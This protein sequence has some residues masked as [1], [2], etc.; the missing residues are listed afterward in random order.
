[1]LSAA[2]A[3]VV[4]RDP[5]LLGLRAL[6]DPD[7]LL[8]ILRQLLGDAG[9]A[10]VRTRYV[11]YKPRTSCLVGF[12]IVV[13]DS[14]QLIGH[15][16]AF[17]PAD[18][19]KLLKSASK[20]VR[21]RSAGNQWV[22]ER[23]GILVSLFPQDSEIKVLPWLAEDA[24]RTQ[25]LRKLLPARPGLWDAP[26]ET[27]AYKPQRR[28][29][30]RLSGQAA[31]EAAVLKC[32][33]G[34]AFEAADPAARLFR[35][36]EILRLAKRIGR[37]RRHRIL[38][39]EWLPGRLLLDVLQNASDADAVDAVQQTAR[40]VAELHR[41]RPTSMVAAPADEPATALFAAAAEV[42]FISPPLADRA[43]E[44]ASR[45]GASLAAAG[46]AAASLHGDFYP[47]QVVLQPDHRVALIDLDEVM[48]GPAELDLGNFAA[49]LHRYTLCGRVPEDRATAAIG[50]L[51]DAYRAAG[52][53]ADSRRLAVHTAAGL[54]RL[55]SQ[56]FRNREDDWPTGI[57]RA[58]QLAERLL[59]RDDAHAERVRSTGQAVQRPA[60]AAADDS[61]ADLQEPSKADPTMPFIVAALDPQAAEKEFARCPDVLEAIGVGA[62]VTRV[63]AVRHRPGRRCLIEYD[64]R[65]PQ[66][67]PFS[68]VGKARAKGLDETGYGLVRSL[69]AVGFGD[70]SDDRVSVPQPIGRVPAWRMWLQR[71]VPGVSSARLLSE[72]DGVQLAQRIAA[73]AMK[74]H[75]LGPPS[76]RRHT[77]DDELRILHAQLSL[78]AAQYP[79]WTVRL[80]ELLAG[81]DRLAAKMPPRPPL[82]GI[83]RDFYP[84]QVHVDVTNDR[85]YVLDLD[86]YCEGDPAVDA[87]N[88][89]AHLTEHGLR[90]SGDPTRLR[91]REQAIAEQ[92]VD[93]YG[94]AIA[95]RVAG[96]AALTLAR[97]VFISTRIAQRSRLTEQLLQLVEARV[98]SP[99]Q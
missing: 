1:M 8:A 89:I 25:L 88:F 2:D 97:H 26:L 19:L 67:E 81:C 31:R 48:L 34:R 62:R 7:H 33:A 87:G 50:V 11:R 16:K 17:G 61:D 70:D 75:H 41:Q 90:E 55:A 3:L 54:M 38:A 94:A 44:L 93:C 59:P 21:G 83:H 29:V 42:G 46:S 85:L 57:E 45:I 47:K 98:K 68:L 92:F 58:I 20:T 15:A 65:P 43:N 64:V 60:A 40:A 66:G 18:Q 91:D 13:G 63:R 35:S 28:Y 27:L 73:A 53:L 9:A 32:Y 69:R 37:S 5:S 80:N 56:P 14:T 10:A 96:Y 23:L 4:S 71:K 77:L 74:L 78:V 99:A 86:L 12:D 49:H 6:L 72:P 95:P 30:A 39:L 22:I 82:C 84:D 52:G 79:E 24:S 36:G 51:A 76:R